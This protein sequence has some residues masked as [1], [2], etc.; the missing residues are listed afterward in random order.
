MNSSDKEF[1]VPMAMCGN[2]LAEGQRDGTSAILYYPFDLGQDG[3]PVV[4]LSENRH[5]V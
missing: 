4:D 1:S 2:L 5:F 3:R